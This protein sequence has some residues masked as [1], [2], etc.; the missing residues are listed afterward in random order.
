MIPVLVWG[1]PD[2]PDIYGD[3]QGVDH[4]NARNR[5]ITAV[6]SAA[7]VMLTI[8]VL[9]IPTA[10]GASQNHFRF[11]TQPANAERNA[12][13]T[14]NDFVAGTNFVQVELVDA[15]DV[16]VTNSNLLVTFTLATGELEPGVAAASGSL[17]VTPQPLVNGVAT[18][19]AGTLS[20]GTLNEP[21]FTSYALIPKNTKGPKIPGDTSQGFDV[22]EDGD[23]CS[24]GCETSIRGGN[25]VYTVGGAGNLGA[26][27]LPASVLANMEC[28]GQK[29]IFSSSVFVHETEDFDS[30]SPDP[31]FV[32]NHVTRQDMKA[33]ANNGQAHIQWCLGLKLASDWTASGGSFVAQDTN[34][35]APGGTLFVGIAP[36]CPNANPQNFAPCIVSQNG[37]GNG[38]SVTLG[39]LP[40]GDPPR[41]T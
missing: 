40:G 1:A 27:Q 13:I 16:P 31:V 17:S 34:G 28:S 19:G 22:W 6:L 30:T 29:L 4:L 35:A 33:A 7:A 23:T 12:T 10:Q 25:D 15:D 39:W 5:R 20:I 14:S 36:P 18:F 37:D 2:L 41:R 24:D 38:G 32:S 11:V 3:H 21:Q 8:S 26:S 9:A